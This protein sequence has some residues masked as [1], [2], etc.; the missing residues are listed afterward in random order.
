MLQNQS[1]TDDLWFGHTEANTVATKAFV[2]EPGG[3]AAINTNDQGVWEL[4]AMAS[5]AV[6]VEYVLSTSGTIA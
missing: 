4:W 6:A 3:V 1:T 2:L 5:G